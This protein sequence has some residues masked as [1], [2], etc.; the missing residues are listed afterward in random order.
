[1]DRILTDGELA[2]EL[3]RRSV[4]RASEFSWK[5]AASKLLAVFSCD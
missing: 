2:R 4:E 1:M 3:S 5:T